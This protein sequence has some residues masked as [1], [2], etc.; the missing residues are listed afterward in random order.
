M[1]PRESLAVPA[2]YAVERASSAAD[3]RFVSCVVCKV[4][5]AAPATPAAALGMC[6]I[7]AY[8]LRVGALGNH[9]V[10]EM[11]VRHRV[12][13]AVLAPFAL[14]A[15]RWESHAVQGT[16]VRNSAVLA[17]APDYVS[18]ALLR[19]SLSIT[20]SSLVS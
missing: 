6:A 12:L 19:V 4:A 15:A 3:R 17:V 13:S 11:P 1:V 9:A 14:L 18:L 7:A 8:A 10:R 20:W 2:G 16:P 5:P